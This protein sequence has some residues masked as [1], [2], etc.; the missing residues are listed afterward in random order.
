MRIGIVAILGTIGGPRDL[1]INQIKVLSKEDT[2]NT[3]VIFCDTKEPIKDISNIKIIEVKPYSN[4]L[5]LWWEQVAVPLAV[6]RER[7]DVVY[8]SKNV[9]PLMRFAKYMVYIHDMAP[10]LMEE[11][12]SPL[13]RL[14]I[15]LN[16]PLAA[17]LSDKIVTGSMSAKQDI[18]KILKVPEK[19]VALI[20]PGIGPQYQILSDKGLL[21]RTRRN[22]RLPES[23]LL[24]V[25][26]IQPRKNIASIIRALGL[27]KEEGIHEHLVIVG[28]AGWALE[29]I[30]RLIRE[31]GLES[32]VTFTSNVPD[33]DL[34]SI[35]NLAK[36]FVYPSFYEGFGLAIAEAMACGVPVIS[37]KIS[38]I[39]E[40]VGDAGILINPYDV[41][42][43]K[44]SIRR[45][46]GD[47]DLRKDMREKGLEKVKEYSW[48]NYAKQFSAL[49][50]EL[51]RRTG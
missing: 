27:L 14:Y 45:V 35:Y 43:L 28:R 42:E 30:R 11:T 24:Y 31:L 48:K 46:I 18:I 3:Y 47:A 12:F 7:I 33:A 32:Q 22:Y 38:S 25:G 4:I 51:G 50:F 6:R 36:A 20:Y 26:T 10:F 5:S 2:Q 41:E 13:R 17:K 40:V 39:P 1:V 19:K 34:V 23:F 44:R 16:I 29:E 37:S 21:E 9:V 49:L 8:H 15:K